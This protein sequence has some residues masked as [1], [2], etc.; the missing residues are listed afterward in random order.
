MPERPTF[1]QLVALEPRL[2]DLFTRVK[3]FRRSRKRI[4]YQTVLKE[5]Y[6][7]GDGRGL[8]GEVVHLV[9]SLRKG[10]DPI[11]QT[12]AAYGVAYDTVFHALNGR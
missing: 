8:R 9:G 7:R 6:G 2:A 5:W 4:G 1:E 3:E 12:P 11:L 10:G